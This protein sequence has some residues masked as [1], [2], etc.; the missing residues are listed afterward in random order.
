M[1]NPYVKTLE[2]VWR[3]TKDVTI[4]EE[5]L[6]KLIQDMKQKTENLIIPAWDA[7]D[8]QPPMNCKS[9]E[10]IDFVCWT[11]T[12]NFAFTNFKPP[13]EK[14]AIEYP[15]GTIWKGAYAMT[16]SFMRA[17]KEGLPV[18]DA[19]HM[20]R[21]TLKEVRHI[22]RPI[23]KSHQIPMIRERWEI[24]HEIGEVLFE[25]YNGSWIKLFLDGNWR[26]F[27][28]G[29][30]IVERLVA[31]FPSFRDARLYQDR[32]GVLRHL[33]FNKRAQ[34]LVMEYHGRAV[35][36]GAR[37]PEIKDIVDIGPIADY[38]VP[39]VFHFLGI[40]Q[41]SQKLGVAIQNH[42]T[43]LCGCPWEVENRLAMSYVMQK[44]CDEVGINMAQADYYI[45]E[46][47]RKSKE[48]HILVQTK[49]Y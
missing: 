9:A 25:K 47:G 19:K 41:Y 15:V 5:K 31:D 46:M 36:S 45:W 44:I 27:N 39:K 26:A 24:F 16:A 8:A 4:N 3:D 20:S 32:N 23:D 48:P 10:W 29:E 11:N 14:F 6:Q 37:M 35:N 30:G 28:G 1:N 13:Y 34:L 12:I 42:E 7:P 40:L 21:I 38:E 49:D 43:I 17:Q 22:F 33:W 18:F 2:P